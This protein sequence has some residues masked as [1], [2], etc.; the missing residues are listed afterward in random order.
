M[1]RVAKELGV[2]RSRLVDISIQAYAY[3]VDI[4]KKKEEKAIEEMI[5]QVKA[6]KKAFE[7]LDV[8]FWREKSDSFGL[9]EEYIYQFFRELE[10]KN[11][12]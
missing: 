4:A 9:M 11:A 2:T 6:F 1:D 10:N 7:E 5:P 12:L 3:T 8:T